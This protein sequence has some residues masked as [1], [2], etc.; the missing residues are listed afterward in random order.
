M[1]S[2]WAFAQEL[3]FKWKVVELSIGHFSTG[4]ISA[5]NKGANLFRFTLMWELP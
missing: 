1:S 3:G 2:R 4:G 5:W